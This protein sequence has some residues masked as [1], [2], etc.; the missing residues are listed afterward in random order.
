MAP[1]DLILDLSTTRL[2]VGEAA[3][4]AERFVTANARE[5]VTFEITS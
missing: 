5:D 1:L 3:L 2:S 4:E